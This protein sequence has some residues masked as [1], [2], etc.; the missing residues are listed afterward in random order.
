MDKASTEPVAKRPAAKQAKITSFLPKAS[1]VTAVAPE[2][3]SER[4][5]VVNEFTAT[6]AQTTPKRGRPKKSAATPTPSV[7][8]RAAESVPPP[9]VESAPSAPIAETPTPVATPSKPP[10]KRS[11]KKSS[12]P[13]VTAS[14]SNSNGTP[15]SAPEATTST[16]DNSQPSSIAPS[17]P[18]E[19]PAPSS[20]ST[21]DVDMEAQKSAPSTDAVPSATG[22]A[23]SL[24]GS[25]T[26]KKRGRAKAGTS[27]TPRTPKNEDKLSYN[28]QRDQLSGQRRDIWE[29]PYAP[30]RIGRS[31]TKLTSTSNYSI[32]QHMM[33]GN[34]NWEKLKLE[35]FERS[36]RDPYPHWK[37][38]TSSL[39]MI[40]PSSRQK[41]YS[42]D[43][44]AVSFEFRDAPTTVPEGSIS[45]SRLAGHRKDTHGT[46]FFLNAGG[47]V[48]CL[49]WCPLPWSALNKKELPDPSFM[50]SFIAV[51]TMKSQGRLDELGDQ[52]NSENMIQIWDIGPLSNRGDTGKSK[53]AATS[54]TPAPK[55]TPFMSIGI[56]HSYG[57]ALSIAWCPVPSPQPKSM[58]DLQL[59]AA[60]SRRR[61][62]K[63]KASSTSSMDEDDQGDAE[64]PRL[65]LL[66]AVLSNGSVVI[67]SVP[68][69]HALQ[70]QFNGDRH[71]QEPI[72]LHLT[73]AAYL[74][75]P[76][77]SRITRIAWSHHWRGE[78]IAAGSNDGKVA[79]WHLAS[80]PDE[81][82]DYYSDD[83][84]EGEEID[85]NNSTPVPR[86][87]PIPSCTKTHSEDKLADTV[88]KVGIWNRT[89]TG[90]ENPEDR[91]LG[92][93]APVAPNIDVFLSKS[94]YIPIFFRNSH[95]TT[96][97]AIAWHPVDPHLFAVATTKVNSYLW[98]VQ[99]PEA[100]QGTVN[101][102]GGFVN[103]IAFGDSEVEYGW[104]AATDYGEV[105]LVYPPTTSIG[106]IHI[107][108]CR[109]VD[110]SQMLR[111]RI[112]A[113]CD[114]LVYL[115]SVV[116]SRT[117]R[118]HF[119]ATVKPIPGVWLDRVTQRK[120]NGE[121]GTPKS[122]KKSPPS[123]VMTFAYDL[124]RCANELSPPDAES[125]TGGRP[126]KGEEKAPPK[127]KK[128]GAY[129]RKPNPAAEIKDILKDEL[130]AYRFE[131]SPDTFINKIRWS[132][133][134][135]T[136]SWLAYGTT[137]GLIR[138]RLVPWACPPDMV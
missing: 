112:S 19:P 8:E 113:G 101:M 73:P 14:E 2:L 12:G 61:R 115:A 63:S 4:A 122:K 54:S 47:P 125:S 106:S 5:L 98:N 42:G 23:E 46:D 87:P 57:H 114:G 109:T 69:P 18:V 16:T 1:S 133:N 80:N 89:A 102:G 118:T 55:F 124:T 136:P 128:A 10:A 132:P 20:N 96:T 103:D 65:G 44:N 82:D 34:D 111:L 50:H 138:V 31:L 53:P 39:F 81:D 27:T 84:D 48:N 60:K 9:V 56:C 104:M 26:P 11:A 108:P 21:M 43:H 86:Y 33:F 22:E 77:L 41:Y 32:G 107:A 51:S 90:S 58:E 79:V 120:T 131:A 6:P 92:L 116:D 52:D 40:D 28:A 85:T 62:D 88:P 25:P 24:L 94:K 78:R 70:L 29:P 137:S 15:S 36:Q 130:E 117:I 71:A 119:S 74:T 134:P 99:H 17:A 123:V 59:T 68:H 64:V 13:K 37:C 72:F 110:Y 121:G 100:P 105:R 126:K 91:D 127:E 95:G 135:L 7:A 75:M 30:G 35:H 97:T 76:D 66:A 93:L 38:L 3:T 129:R 49:E 45:L 83:D 67:Y